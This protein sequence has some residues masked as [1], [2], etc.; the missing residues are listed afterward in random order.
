[1]LKPNENFPIVR[2]PNYWYRDSDLMKIEHDGSPFMKSDLKNNGRSKI[3]ISTVESVN[4]RQELCTICV[5]SEIIETNPLY[6]ETAITCVR[7]RMSLC[8]NNHPCFSSINPTYPAL[9]YLFYKPVGEKITSSHERLRTRYLSE[10]SFFTN[11]LP[12]INLLPEL[13]KKISIM[14]ALLFIESFDWIYQI[15]PDKRNK[16]LCDFK[17]RDHFSYLYKQLE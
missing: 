9:S 1:M 13:R 5:Y 17:P 12:L 10:W 15:I 2:H 3:T 14:V 6:K 8:S 16:T 11:I 7:C 4:P